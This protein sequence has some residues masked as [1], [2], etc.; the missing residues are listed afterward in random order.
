MTRT[1]DLQLFDD[2]LLAELQAQAQQAL[3]RRAHRLL[4]ASHDEPV[5]RM[6]VAVETDS[7]IRP[8]WHPQVEKWELLTILRGSLAYL[9][10]DGNGRVTHRW[11]L[12]PAGPTWGL[13]VP[14]G[15][16]HS[17]VALEAGSVFLEVKQGPFA[18]LQEQ[19]FA[20]WSPAPESD[21]AAGFVDWMRTA[22]PGD[23]YQPG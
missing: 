18:P 13:E 11:L 22:G 10:F 6:L 15:S 9:L 19:D 1:T 8:H 5:Q 17:L 3:R 12:S 23:R 14:A 21:Q 2:R 20:A 16:W 4:H 7:Y